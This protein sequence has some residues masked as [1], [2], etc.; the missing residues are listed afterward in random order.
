[1]DHPR[2]PCFFSKRKRNPTSE[3]NDGVVS[4]LP[5]YF[6]HSQ[7]VTF[8]GLGSGEVDG[9]VEGT[10]NQFQEEDGGVNKLPEYIYSIAYQ[11]LRYYY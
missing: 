9:E 1:M 6:V 5:K 4:K 2:H 10:D 11:C 7:V 8:E 3:T